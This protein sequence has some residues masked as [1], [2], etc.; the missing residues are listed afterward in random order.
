MLNCAGFGFRIWV[1]L[2]IK[3]TWNSFSEK[4]I[5]GLIFTSAKYQIELSLQ[6]H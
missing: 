1:N 4:Q 6:T 2:I 5:P 3:K